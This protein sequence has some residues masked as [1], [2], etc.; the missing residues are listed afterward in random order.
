M[1]QP[2]WIQGYRM[3]FAVLAI[4]AVIRKYFLDNDPLINY[5][6][7]FTTQS[8]VIAAVVLLGGVLLGPD[9]LASIGW[10]RIRGAAVVYIL[11]TFIVYGLLLSGFDNPFNTT[12]HWTHTVV[13]QI[14]PLI[15]VLDLFIR[16]LVH[17]LDWRV[18]MA[19]TVY[20]IVYLAYSLT[21]GSIVGWYP[22][23]FINPHEVGGYD[24]VA[25]Y[26]VGIAVGFLILGFL[27][28]WM[29]HWYHRRPVTHRT[30]LPP[31]G[32]V[33]T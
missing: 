15:M 14:I 25:L 23:N 11:T 31:G 16:P 10:N 17:R 28:V 20:P 4:V 22:Y 19:W 6:S 2:L 21:R 30:L 32:S 8:N 13:H 3:V 1:D 26:S 7:A 33:H 9:R 27:I 24:G 18:A 5:L 12:R 29:S